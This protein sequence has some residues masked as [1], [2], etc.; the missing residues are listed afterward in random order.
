MGMETRKNHKTADVSQVLDAT[1]TASLDA[2]KAQCDVQ[3]ITPGF[4]AETEEDRA[5]MGPE[6]INVGCPHVCLCKRVCSFR[7]TRTS[8]LLC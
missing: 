3:V 4:C 5:S 6:G 1:S 2:Q 8:A 7:C